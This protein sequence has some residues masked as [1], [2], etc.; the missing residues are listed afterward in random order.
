M[1]PNRLRRGGKTRQTGR[2][3]VAN[4][5]GPLAENTFPKLLIRNARIFAD[6]PAYRHKDFGIWQSWT[7]RRVL[8]EVRAF[9]IGLAERGV[10]RDDRVAI[11]GSNRPR[12]YWAMCDAQAL[13][14]VPVRL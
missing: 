1:A 9:S 11:I 3:P 5:A 4:S 14:A 13:V 6:R 10:K 12:W 8:D 2:L 7:W